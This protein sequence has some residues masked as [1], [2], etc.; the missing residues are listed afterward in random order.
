M[1]NQQ[2]N[3]CLISTEWE[4][5]KSQYVVF[6]WVLCLV[7]LAAF[8][9]L[10]FMTKTILAM[11]LVSVFSVLI[12]LFGIFHSDTERDKSQVWQMLVLLFVFLIV[13]NYHGRLVEI[14]SRLDFLW[15]QVAERELQDMTETRQNNSQ[16]LRNILPDHVASH[17]LAR[18]RQTEVSYW[19]FF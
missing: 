19:F 1:S 15:K 12:I 3:L 2:Y 13:V 11:V 18:D 5:R 14:T 17:F 4:K 10:N 7:A 16:L 9:K 8:L 6:S